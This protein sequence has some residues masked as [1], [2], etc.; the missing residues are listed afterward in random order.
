MSKTT[1][2]RRSF[3]RT[4]AVAGAG[5]TALAAAGT[6]LA[7]APASAE[8]DAL[9]DG[10]APEG[11]A[12][13][14]PAPAGPMGG[15]VEPGSMCTR[16][17]DYVPAVGEYPVGVPQ[18]TPQGL[19]W[20][21]VP[22]P[23]TD[24]SEEKTA[25]VVVV[26][27][28]ITGLAAAR[29]AAEEGASVIVIEA[30]DTWQTRGQDVGTINSEYQKANGLECDA[31]DINEVCLEMQKYTGNRANQAIMRTWANRSGEDYD[32]W[33]K[34]LLEPQ[35]YGIE[36]P[37]WPM[38]EQEYDPVDGEWIPQ[39]AFQ[40]EFT[41]PEGQ[42]TGFNGGMPGA[43]DLLA[44]ASIDLGAE[45]VFNT[46]ARQL[47]R[48]EDNNTGRV[49]AVIAEDAD[50]NYVKLNANKG[51]ILAT[52]DYGHN[53]DLMSVWCPMYADMARD[54]NVY[55]TTANQG[56][57][58]LMGMWVGGMMQAIPHP[59]M[60]HGTPGDQGAY[61]GL[62]VDIN[63]RRFTNEDIP[64][65]NFSNIAELQPR[66]V[67]YLIT[68]ANYPNHLPMQ[69]PGHGAN[70][71]FTGDLD[72]WNA[73][74]ATG[75]QATIEAEMEAQGI[76]GTVAWTL[77]ELAEAIHVDP[78]VLYETVERYNEM[79]A[80]GRDDDFGKQPKRLWPID[81]PPYFYSTS[82]WNFLVVMGGLETT[83]KAEVID[84][85]GNPIPGLYAAGNVQGGRFAVDYPTI[86]CGISHSI[87]LT[88]GR[89]A[90]TEA[91]TCDPSVTEYKSIY[92]EWK[93][94]QAAETDAAAAEAAGVE[95]VDGTYT[96]SGKGIGG[97]VPVTVTI[98]G[99]KI[100]S[101][102][103]GENSETQGI[104]SKA[105]EQLPDEIVTANGTTGVDAV[106]GASVTSSAIFS[107]V[108][109]C[110]SQAGK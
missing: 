99:G 104:G 80:Q 72:A 2:D 93:E 58:H 24:I 47:V 71:E 1:L 109:D 69:Q 18:G 5:F 105:I 36:I 59:H 26:G 56:D 29:A 44:Q 100:A 16:D 75:D 97:D 38:T 33:Y 61:P 74:V 35:G 19:D 7:D 52:G 95:Y 63:G 68:D 54:R 102:E 67:W 23:I 39:F 41:V 108:E 25:D 34:G 20:M 90:G 81:T 65:Q 51:V 70:M 92:K 27:A 22:E 78:A 84:Q 30:T 48:G 96:A 8:G 3:L 94:S 66:M 110:L 83:T 37:R 76:S 49:T 88:Y 43:I 103:V 28:G 6:A 9:A 64:G 31:D 14:A 17:V 98:S 82:S 45:F 106:S 4:A 91:A 86:V 89:I 46:R 15:P 85:F 101:V 107:A 42:E 32:W 60:A 10:D 73:A 12:A 50:G 57:G 77:D 55:S 79:C 40:Q 87:C 62:L 53:Y 13:G 11:D 21:A